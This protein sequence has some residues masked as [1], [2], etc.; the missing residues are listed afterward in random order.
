[1]R[2]SLAV[3][4]PPAEEPVGLDELKRALRIDG[5]DEDAY[6][7]GLLVAAREVVE[8]ET[9][10]ATVLTEYRLTADGFGRELRLPRTP[11][12]EVTGVSYYDYA[13]TLRTLD[14]SGY[15]LL[16]GDHMR[17]GRLV[18]AYQTAW[19][20]VRGFR[21]DVVVTFTAG[22]ADAASVPAALK[23]QIT[24]LA[25]FWYERPESRG[26]SIRGFDQAYSA[27]HDT[28]SV[29]HIA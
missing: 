27:V 7:D 25:G 2:Y 26:Q 18:A 28:N 3:E 13:G 10:R 23:R 29:P 9:G 20:Q 24:M 6:L 1:M 5:D 11:V 14:G 19:P 22:Y 4:T 12:V 21:D 17:A 15:A 8:A 16:A